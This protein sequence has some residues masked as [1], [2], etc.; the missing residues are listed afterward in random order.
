MSLFSRSSTR[1]Y[2]TC[3]LP[4][5]HNHLCSIS[6]THSIPNLFDKP[7]AS[8]VPFGPTPVQPV[9]IAPASAF[10]NPF[11]PPAVSSTET[12]ELAPFAFETP[13][14]LPSSTLTS[15]LARPNPPSIFGTLTI[16]RPFATSSPT[17]TAVDA[18]KQTSPLFRFSASTAQSSPLGASSPQKFPFGTSLVSKSM[19]N[20]GAPS[21]T[22]AFSTAPSSDGDAK[23]TDTPLLIF[24]ASA[25]KEDG[26]K[27]GTFTPAV[28]FGGA[29]FGANANSVSSNIFDKSCAPQPSGDASTSTTT[30]KIVS[31]NATSNNAFFAAPVVSSVILGG[32]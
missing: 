1:L 17:A 13:S 21:R 26:S 15:T 10:T 29:D 4:R 2:P 5:P 28:C 14:I 30:F 11:S 12:S 24:A 22:S 16:P 32:T 3:S 19:P 31:G 8:A 20:F 6:F 18:A 7:A 27:V 23:T 9:F 25:T